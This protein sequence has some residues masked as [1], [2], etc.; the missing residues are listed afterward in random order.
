MARIAINGFGRIGRAVLKQA[1]DTPD[2]E[3][4]A[5]ND[6]NALDN[7]AYLLRYDTVY[8]RYAGSV[9]TA[10]GHLIIDGLK[11]P[12]LSRRDPAALPWRDLGV[13]LVFECTGR[14][15]TRAALDA[16]VAAGARYALLSAP[17]KDDGMPTFIPGVNQ[18]PSGAAVLSCASCTT[19]CVAPLIEIMDRRIGVRKSA[20]TT[21][22]AYTASQS[23][24]DK[25]NPKFRRGRAGA[26]N[27]VPSSTGAATATA[28]V[29]PAVRGRFDG[30][31]MRAPVACG[32]IADLVFVTVRPTTVDEVT[33][34][35][36]DEAA[37]ERYRGI[38]D[39][40]HDPIVSSDVLQQPRAAIVDL[41]LTQVIDGDLVKLMGWYDNEWGYASQ[42][43]R[44]AR[45]LLA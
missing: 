35:F 27:L 9:Q 39:V 45:R 29:L 17:P 44:A 28:R 4:V 16:H 30:L 42:L 33:R 11:L 3:P 20:M 19:N 31:A 2:L 24:V 8:G 6:T 41:R 25:A 38:V 36:E 37:G 34:V 18:P 14:F 1:L 7:L 40:T 5:I 26:A 15:N 32:A 23:I 22:H 43:I 21:V 10:D 13:D 12:V